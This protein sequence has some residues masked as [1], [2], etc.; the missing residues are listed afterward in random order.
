MHHYGLAGCSAATESVP[1]TSPVAEYA[2][3]LCRATRQAPGVRLG[4]SPRSAIWLIRAA[5][6]HALLSG[7]AYVAPDDVKSVAVGCL[8]HRIVTND[9]DDPSGQGAQV[10]RR[11]LEDDARTAAVT[12]RVRPARPVTP[13]VVS[14]LVLGTWWLV[15]HNSGAGWVQALGDIVFGTLVVGMVG[16]AL[17]LART[18][19]RIERG[20]EDGMALEPLEVTVRA[21]SRV[22]V[23]PVDLSGEDSFVGPVRRRRVDGSTVTLLPARRGVHTS[24]TVEVATASPFGLQWWTRRLSLP[25]PAPLYVS[26]RRGTPFGLPPRTD[27]DAGQSRPRQPAPAGE[28]RAV[29]PYRPGDNRR[30]VHWPAT[31]HTGELMVREMEGPVAEPVMV[32]VVLPGDPDEAERVAERALG[33]VLAL[34]GRGDAVILATH[35]AFGETIAPVTDR[36]G[37][38]RRLAQATSGQPWV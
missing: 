19:V 28:A 22:R 27:D 13:M 12:G 2:V 30:H 15:A 10:V 4:A 18:R 24:V 33:T 9:S 3:G 17:I 34:L 16:P 37:A 35:E 23:R 1:V 6:A 36:H 31:A 26:P 38:G 32:S 8:A 25:L 21:T 29:R 11:L 7:R 5:Q 14:V 20:Q